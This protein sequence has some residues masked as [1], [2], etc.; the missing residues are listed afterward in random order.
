MATNSERILALE[1]SV[2]GFGESLQ[3][4]SAENVGLKQ[5]ILDIDSKFQKLSVK[6]VE[7]PAGKKDVSNLK[8]PGGEMTPEEYFRKEHVKPFAGGPVAM[9]G[10]GNIT[11]P[12]WRRNK[13]GDFEHL[14]NAGNVIETLKKDFVEKESKINI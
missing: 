8:N 6:P 4:V 3:K 1:E 11:D 9:D 10:A 7:K 12:T 14:D 13:D 5:R 2:K